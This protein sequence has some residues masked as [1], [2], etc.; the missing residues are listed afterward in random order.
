[1]SNSWL[2]VLLPLTRVSLSDAPSCWIIHFAQSPFSPTW[3]FIAWND[4]FSPD[5]AHMLFSSSLNFFRYYGRTIC[6]FIQVHKAVKLALNLDLMR[7]GGGQS[8]WP[9]EPGIRQLP[10]FGSSTSLSLL[11][12]PISYL[13]ERGGTWI[14]IL[15]FVFSIVEINAMEEEDRGVSWEKGG[16]PAHLKSIYTP[17]W[18]SSFFIEANSFPLLKAVLFV[19][20]ISY[21]IVCGT[22][23]LYGN[24]SLRKKCFLSGER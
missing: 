1:M 23:L 12:W 24:T 16:F 6:F 4:V 3:D 9:W 11:I 5:T 20:Y 13:V 21:P 2:F 18:D 8:W 7:K 22:I 14:N 17:G 19:G 15:S 10:I